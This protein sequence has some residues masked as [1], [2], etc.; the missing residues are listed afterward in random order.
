MLQTDG[1]P[2]EMYAHALE[3]LKADAK[4][5]VLDALARGAW[6][7][8]DAAPAA[9]YEAKFRACVHDLPNGV[10]KQPLDQVDADLAKYQEAASRKPAN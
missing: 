5:D 7:L 8:G 2:N 4:G 6:R 10:G 1:L 9:E 3:N